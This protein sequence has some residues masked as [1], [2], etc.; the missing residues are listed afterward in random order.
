MAEKIKMTEWSFHYKKKIM[1]LTRGSRS[2][3]RE[4]S[5][6]GLGGLGALPP[7]EPSAV[8]VFILSVMMVARMV[9][10]LTMLVIMIGG[11]VMRNSFGS[12]SWCAH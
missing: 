2:S 5:L 9:M 11:M 7:I 1:T 4:L 3:L 10:T 6:S 12:Q 8:K